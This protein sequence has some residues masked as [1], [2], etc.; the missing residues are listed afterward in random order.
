M[1]K[2]IWL[3]M[4]CMILAV[5]S[6]V[7]VADDESL[8][9]PI[10]PENRAQAQMVQVLSQGEIHRLTWSPDAEQIAVTAEGGTWIYDV[11]G[12]KPPH[13]LRE[14]ILRSYVAYAPH[15]DIYISY[16]PP[17]FCPYGHCEDDQQVLVRDTNTHEVLFDIRG[18]TDISVEFSHDGELV[19][20]GSRYYGIVIW[21]TDSFRENIGKDPSE[22]YQCQ[23]RTP[24]EVGSILFSQDDSII[25]YVATRASYMMSPADYSIWF[26][27]TATCEV[28]LQIKVF[29]DDYESVPP[30]TANM[31]LYVP[32]GPYAIISSWI[33]SNR[34]LWDVKAGQA[35]FTIPRGFPSIW[36]FT[37]DN[38][39]LLLRKAGSL[40]QIWHIQSQTVTRSFYADDFYT[41]DDTHL[42]MLRAGNL[43]RINETDETLIRDDESDITEIHFS[44]DKQ[45][46][47][48][49]YADGHMILWE[50]ATDT[51][52]ERWE[53]Q[54][55]INLSPDKSK[56]AWWDYDSIFIWDIAKR[57]QTELFY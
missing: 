50:W 35:L 3:L 5:S 51:V 25:S 28:H 40:A 12:Q 32:D 30:P 23:V 47:F 13:H 52:I 43:Y 19:A 17:D 29:P 6:L 2:I 24:A 4:L 18:M 39:H 41:L 27:D 42:L 46:L 15:D 54:F 56:I 55:S 22:F 57:E 16:S 44:D 8:F 10:T 34:Q 48:L 31:D 36:G 11:T 49:T 9:P 33:D 45:W 53:S 1:K 37:P 14:N 21:R 38:Q 7:A 26:W 20:V